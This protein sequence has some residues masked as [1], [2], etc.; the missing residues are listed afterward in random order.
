MTKQGG[1]ILGVQSARNSMLAGTLLASSTL[2]IAFELIKEFYIVVSEFIYI[3]HFHSKP[4][5]IF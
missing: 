1:E 3:Y 2:I 5:L 4:Y